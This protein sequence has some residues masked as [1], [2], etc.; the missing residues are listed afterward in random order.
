M[1]Y[2]GRKVKKEFEGHGTFF[3]SVES[4]DASTRFFKIVYEDGDSEELDLTEISSLLVSSEG[5]ESAREAQP[6]SAEEPTRRLVRKRRKRSHMN[7]GKIGISVIESGVSGN[8]GDM[9]LNA[10]GLNLNE[11]LDLND[12]GFNNLN[13]DYEGTLGNNCDVGGAKLQ[14]VNLNEAVNL[15]SRDEGMALSERVSDDRLGKRKELIDL[16][17]DVNEDS[18]NFSPN[19]KRVC[20]DLNLELSENE[21]KNPDYFL[22]QFEKNENLCAEEEKLEGEEIGGE[23]KGILFNVEVEKGNANINL[24]KIGVSVENCAGI[25]DYENE[26]PVSAPRGRRGRKRRQVSDNN[27]NSATP[28]MVNMDGESGNVIINSKNNNETPWESGSGVL[29]YDY[30]VPGSE[31]GGRRGRK[32]R[33]LSDDN[34]PSATPETGLRRS[35]RRV[36]RDSFSG[37]DHIFN[38]AGLDGVA[39]QLSSP[40]IS[41]VWEEKIKALGCEIFEENILPPKVELPPSSGNLDLNGVPAF[42]ILSI[43]AFLRSFSISLFLSPFELDDFVASVKCNY[44]TLL[45]DSI[46]FSLLQTLRKHLMSLSNEGDM[47]SSNCLRSLNWDL[48]D[49]ITWPMFAVEYLLLYSSEYIPGFDLCHLKLSQSD[50]Y[51]I[52]VSTKIEILQRL[53]DDAMEVEYIRLE[54]N[55]RTLATERQGGF[56]RTTKSDSSKKRK[57]M[58]D[59]ASSSCI[60]EE[61]VEET[62]DWNSDECR[63]CKMDGNLICCD[64]CPAAFHSRCV[65]VVSSLLPEGDWYCP[66]CAINKD[67]PWMKMEKSIRGA[68]LLGMDPYHRQYYSSCGYLLVRSELCNDEYSFW[69]YHK[70]D[71]PTIIDS[72]ESSP[73]VYGTIITAVSKHWNVTHGDDGSKTD[74]DAHSSIHSLFPIKGLL[75]H[76][77]PTP[78][79]AHIK[80]VAER[81]SEEKSIVSTYPSNIEPGVPECV[82][83]MLGTDNHGAKMEN[84]L[85][86]SEGSAEVFQSVTNTDNIKESG[87]DCS[88]RGTGI[89]SYNSEIPSKFVN[90]GNHY[91]TSTILEIEQRTNLISAN[92]GH[93]PSII[94]PCGI[95]PQ[96]CCA[97]TYVNFYE[98]AWTTSSVVEALMRKSSEKTSEK[99]IR[100]EEEVITGQLKV[101]SSK[102]AYLCWPNIQNLIAKSRKEKCGWC[103]TCQGPEEERDCLFIVNENGP[104]VENFTS[105]VLGFRSRKNMKSHLIDVM[106]QIICTED[107]L[108]GL[109]LGPWLDPQY[110]ELW[111]KSVLGVSDIASLKSF[112]LKLES[113][114]HLRA[115]SADW[116][117]YVDSVPT[118]GSASHV[119]RNSVRASMKHGIG[120]KRARF[121]EL[122]TTSSS[123]SA[124]GLILFW[125]RGG[126]ISRQLFNWKVLPRSLASKAARQGGCKKI[127]GI[128]Y[129]E[130]GEYAKRSKCV[131]WRASVETSIS[132]EQLAFQVR[133]L[134]ANIRWDDIGNPNLLSKMD[135]ESKKSAKLFKKVIIRRKCSEGSVVR[136]LL[137]F[138]K[139]RFIPDIVVIHGSMLEDSSSERKKYWLEESHVPLHLLKTFEEK[140]IARKSNKTCSGKLRESSV[141]TNKTFKEKGFSY[142]FSRAER[143]ENYQ[144]GHCNKDVLIREAVSCQ[145]CKG[146]FHKRHARKSAGS[147]VAQCTYTCHKCLDGKSMEMDTKTGESKPPKSKK[148]S[149]LMKPLGS[150]K[151]K[152]LGK[153]RQRVQSQKNKMVQLLVPL[154]RSARHA[155]P[156]VKTSVLDTKI[157]RRKKGKQ[158]KSKKD[159]PKK[160]DKLKKPKNSSLQKKRTLVNYSYWLNGLRL[161][162]RLNDERVMHFRSNLLVLNGESTSIACMPKCSL[163]GE[164][165]FKSELNYVSCEICG[166]WFHGDAFNL[167][168]EKVEKLIGFKCHKCLYKNPPVCP[169]VCY[170]KQPSCAFSRN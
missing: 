94:D 36:K 166:D 106:C 91:L 111:R 103:F 9:E 137:D 116:L 34:I 18:E 43:Y 155:K 47:S 72:L 1:E 151:G 124:N 90:S 10:V 79:E 21:I 122:D 52:P 110:S 161:S 159:K 149:K 63:L 44:S 17:L 15:E 129:P 87:Q 26:V 3:G 164:L 114:L 59:V 88:E 107:R 105:E 147:I 150:R 6:S 11:G 121:L 13:D 45:F 130:S 131:A 170:W 57:A 142:L 119:V 25:A 66:E 56:V 61:D 109:L 81:K 112:L 146:F 101:I 134:D 64:G 126:R 102:S 163:C 97:A 100:S 156:V 143:L 132:V 71:L 128:L 16:N 23:N 157:K 140:R 104:A 32:R 153:D 139:R 75:P 145:Y 60:T 37:Q 123:S 51:K 55:R 118:M 54:I 69:Y 14:G 125:W 4:Y 38:T 152:K 89:S 84:R 162:R 141:V 108:Q 68:E 67:K 40:A 85:A 154:R 41:S 62:A 120:R 53:C 74:L 127:P 50:Y 73:F 49:L 33:D 92:H 144:C 98:F 99:I 39:D 76:M 22:V 158:A 5:L 24:E 20:F 42:N 115:L 169:H 160:P 7:T 46:H 138:G 77:H 136:Y 48:L 70:N 82:N 95:M 27:V 80:D 12:D 135:K 8:S 167:K 35:N 29:D 93:A 168:A 78:S 133:E 96:G 83:M 2:V 31:P 165:E 113:N 65:G 19:G 117:K 86:S 28:E 30:Q 58:M 148:A